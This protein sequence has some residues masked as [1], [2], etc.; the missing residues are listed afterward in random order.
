MR[1]AL[2]VEKDPVPSYKVWKQIT[3]ETMEKTLCQ[4]AFELYWNSD[5][6]HMECVQSMVNL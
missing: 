6:S 3:I 5:K 1:V 2:A 4:N